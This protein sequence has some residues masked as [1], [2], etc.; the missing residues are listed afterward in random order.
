VSEG[1]ARAE[2]FAGAATETVRDGGTPEDVEIAASF[3]AQRLRH[4][5]RPRTH[6][7]VE[8]AG[9]LEKLDEVIRENLP[10]RIEPGRGYADVRVRRHVGGRLRA[11]AVTEAR[12]NVA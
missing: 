6:G 3:T 12:R 1:R 2:V 11:Q 8:G 7:R 10:E 4:L 5:E 9:E